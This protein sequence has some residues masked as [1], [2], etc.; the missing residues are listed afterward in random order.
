MKRQQ[1]HWILGGCSLVV[2]GLVVHWTREAN[3]RDFVQTE[4]LLSLQAQTLAR[5]VNAWKPEYTAHFQRVVSS[6]PSHLRVL[7]YD[8]SG[9]EIGRA[10]GSGAALPLNPHA[11][12]CVGPHLLRPLNKETPLASYS[13]IPEEIQNHPRVYNRLFASNILGAAWVETLDSDNGET[14]LVATTAVNDYDAVA[15]RS[16]ISA[17][18]QAAMRVEDAM[19]P[20]HLRWWRL[21]GVTLVLASIGSA[22]VWLTR[23]ETLALRRAA[24][25]AERIPNDKLQT[26]RLEEPVHN[27]EALRLVSACNRLLDRVAEIHLSQQRFVSNAAHE[28]RTPLTILRGEIQVALREPGNHPLLIQTLRSNLDEAVHLSKLVDSLLTLARADAGQILAAFKPVDLP[29]LARQT[30]A[31]LAPLAAKQSVRL[32]VQQPPEPIDPMPGDEI[33]LGRILFNLLENAVQHSPADHEVVLRMASSTSGWT[34]A[35]EDHG[36]GIGPE[37]LPKLFDRFYRV[38]AARRRSDGGAGLGLA[39]V[40]TIAEAHQGTVT[41]QSEIGVGTTFT[42]HF[43]RG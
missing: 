15:N 19:R 11:A 13:P 34:L 12:R 8:L 3:R 17:W 20:L 7:L 33:A 25:A 39:I 38:D 30:V 16:F 10:G 42:L 22:W 6:N 18:V 37:H 26:A 28:L 21:A 4:N 14:W 24:A 41:V 27:P 29:A 35:V 9:W 43:P 31:K 2:F 23:R 32:T 40:K 1:L 36:I 5:H